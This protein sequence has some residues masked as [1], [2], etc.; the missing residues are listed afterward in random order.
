MYKLSP[1]YEYVKYYFNGCEFKALH[2]GVNLCWCL[3]AC[4]LVRI[5][6]NAVIHKTALETAASTAE[7]HSDATVSTTVKT[8][9]WDS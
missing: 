7:L 5:S 4:S 6:H 8:G 3:G 9:A 1:N 2:M